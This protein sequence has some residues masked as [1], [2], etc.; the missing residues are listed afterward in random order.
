SWPGAGPGPGAT[1]RLA[2][3]LLGKPGIRVIIAYLGLVG[4][5]AVCSP[6]EVGRDFRLGSKPASPWWAREPTSRLRGCKRGTCERA[7]RART[8]LWRCASSGNWG[9]TK[10]L[11][12]FESG[13]ARAPLREPRGSKKKS[14]TNRRDLKSTGWANAN[15]VPRPG[16][17]RG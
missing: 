9:W 2:P 6:T 15:D 3:V 7:F 5:I 8:L 17:I 11:P 4:Y 16:R 14:R 12:L 1:S 10:R 13:H